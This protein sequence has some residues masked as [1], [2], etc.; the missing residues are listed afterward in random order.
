MIVR[1]HTISEWDRR[2][3]KHSLQLYRNAHCEQEAAVAMVSQILGCSECDAFGLCNSPD[4]IRGTLDN[5]GIE[6][7]PDEPP[8][9]LLDPVDIGTSYEWLETL[10]ICVLAAAMVGVIVWCAVLWWD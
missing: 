1:H 9:R 10:V 6:V 3:L 4:T 5:L 8:L 7:A 2:Q